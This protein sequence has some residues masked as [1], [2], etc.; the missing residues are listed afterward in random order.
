[1]KKFKNLILL[2]NLLLIYSCGVE[3]NSSL[4]SWGCVGPNCQ[5]AINRDIERRMTTN[6]NMQRTA[7]AI[8]GREVYSCIRF[9]PVGPNGQPCPGSANVCPSGP[10]VNGV[11]NWQVRFESN[12]DLMSLSSEAVFNFTG[13]VVVLANN[14][15]VPAFSEVVWS[16]YSGSEAS[17]GNTG[18]SNLASKPNSVSW[19]N[20]RS[21]SVV[22]LDYKDLI[23]D[24]VS[25]R[26]LN[27]S[28][29][30]DLPGVVYQ[31]GR[32]TWKLSLGK[33][34]LATA[35]HSSIK[36]SFETAVIQATQ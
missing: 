21:D 9:S 2:C 5:E 27:R 32:Y 36:S 8:S 12:L 6:W 28:Y 18:I 31:N 26:E 19:Q 34:D 16:R 1:M 13:S 22:T 24:G 11:L 17:V 14:R 20:L 25:N 33:K 7:P 35:L 29:R 15:R 10:R 23:I 30:C 3:N 4:K